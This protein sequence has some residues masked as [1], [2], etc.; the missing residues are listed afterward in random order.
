[1]K[2]AKDSA[3]RHVFAGQYM[4]KPAPEGGDLIRGDW[5]GRYTVAPAIKYRKIYADTAQKTAERNDYSVFECWG[6][7]ENGQI[8]LLDLLRGKWEAPELERRAIDF[9]NKH[10]PTEQ[11]RL[12]ALRKL[13]IEDK[14][15]GT[16][17]IQSI[18][19]KGSIP[20]EGIQRNTDKLIRVKDVVGFIETGLV[21]I[22]AEAPWVAEFIAECEAFTPDD[23]HAHDDQ[24]DPMCDAINDMLA[25]T[26]SIYD[27]L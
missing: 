19:R 9:W 17:L 23:T 12:G 4:Q 27:A 14:A 10:S 22:P 26:K 13:M 24:I 21:N 8:Y 7:G 2:N 3:T 5:F 6:L 25:K 20:V 18:K 15:S 1:M 11:F 16:G